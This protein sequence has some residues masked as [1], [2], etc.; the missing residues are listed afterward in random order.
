ME[1]GAE[2]WATKDT[3]AKFLR[4]T[5]EVFR[6]AERDWRRAE[7]EENFKKVES[8]ASHLQALASLSVPQ[9]AGREAPP[10][11]RFPKDTIANAPKSPKS[12]TMRRFNPPNSSSSTVYSDNRNSGQ[13][14]V[15]LQV[16]TVPEICM[17][18]FS[19]YLPNELTKTKVE[20]EAH[21][22]EFARNVPLTT[23][24]LN[25]S[26]NSLNQEDTLRRLL[27]A[28]T[29]GE[30]IAGSDTDEDAEDKAD[31]QDEEPWDRRDDFRLQ[32]A[33]AT[34]GMSESLRADLAHHLDT[35]PARVQHR[36]AQ[37]KS[38][39]PAPNTTPGYPSSVGVPQALAEAAAATRAGQTLATVWRPYANQVLQNHPPVEQNLNYTSSLAIGGAQ[40]ASKWV[41]P[42]EPTLYPDLV[43]AMDSFRTLFCR[44][45]R[46]FDCKMH[47]C[48]QS[49]PRPHP[50]SLPPMPSYSPLPPSPSSLPPSSSSS[51]IDICG[52]DCWKFL[53]QTT[54]Q[55]KITGTKAAKTIPTLKRK[56]REG[57]KEPESSLQQS[58]KSVDDDL[59]GKRGKWTQLEE[60][61]FQYARQIHGT[62][63]EAAC[64]CAKIVYSR[65]CFEVYSHM[66][67]FITQLQEKE[68]QIGQD[69]TQVEDKDGQQV[70]KVGRRKKSVFST[71][72]RAV[73]TTLR[74]RLE[75]SDNQ[76]LS[77]YYPCTCTDAKCGADSCGCVQ[78]RNFC[79]KYCGCP[80]QCKNRFNGCSCSK[81]QCR[82][83]VCPCFAAGRECDPDLC[84][85]CTSTV[86]GILAALKMPQTNPASRPP[87]I[88]PPPPEGP[89][90]PPPI[91]SSSSA[92]HALNNVLCQ[93]MKL[94]LSQHRHIHLGLSSVAGWG[95]F[96]NQAA[97]KDDFLGEYTGELVTQ[98]EADRRGKVY[99]RAN[100]SF[101]FNLNS[102]W[103]L[104]AHLRGNKLKFANHSI[105]PNCHA[106]VLMVDGNHRV[107][108]F[109]REAIKAG[110]ELF[111]DYRYDKDNAPVWAATNSD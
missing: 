10:L 1:L 28:D 19:H 99:D 33:V 3:R 62:T 70:G 22:L 98:A 52:L 88:P 50:S 89:L 51:A 111:Y 29:D 61:L 54:G 107:G 86:S 108:I 93:N 67:K 26:S 7:M 79:E 64:D 2:G 9:E 13:P 17:V 44:R 45:C 48:G 110:A 41:V 21:V 106:K 38:L 35:T 4:Q 85:M 87:N 103:V 100:C 104:D 24:W 81:G 72:K 69:P 109:A 37:I 25:I 53:S 63:G 97:K 95:A 18:Q 32:A 42:E 66:I 27:Y 77:Q 65:S 8:H 91:T 34:F 68:A 60:D 78:D 105:Q 59:L 94:R 80:P 71:R 11:I 74:W 102:Q 76:L 75:N 49:M 83:R 20:I 5:K 96:L 15:K 47:G 6:A 55:E 73:G 43:S 39:Y 58:N 14:G 56:Q 23:T 36:V 12:S 84:K 31:E 46:V 30:M 90:A 92:G 82:T 40:V 16:D 101:L 57:E